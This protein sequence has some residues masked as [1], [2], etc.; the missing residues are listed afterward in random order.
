MRRRAAILL[1]LASTL[2]MAVVIDRIAVVVGNSI[3]KDSDIDRDIR[4]NSFLN[5]EL[6][7]IDTA[8]RKRSAN[9][10]ID[11]IFIIREMDLGDYPQA[12]MQQAEQEIAQLKK[13]RFKTQA[14]FDN[15]LKRYG[16]SE[17]ELRTQ[18]HFQLT[19]LKFIDVRFRPAVLISDDEVAKYYQA[20]AAALR[21]QYPG[22]SLD[23]IQ[24][25]VRDLLTGE[26]VNKQFF[27]WLDEQR[28]NTTIDFLE[29]G[30]A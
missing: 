30:L 24:D 28:K 4:A 29:K 17:T 15:A 13:D 5:N 2:A 6:L 23:Y 20:H 25:R 7:V 21:R 1:L 9:R 16:L 14:A 19:V 18:F 27:A 10:L 11:Q 22:K 26:Q 12:T 8:T 3:V